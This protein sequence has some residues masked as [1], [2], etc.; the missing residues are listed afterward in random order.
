MSDVRVIR[1]WQTA[2]RETLQVRLR[3]GEFRTPFALGSTA[4]AYFDGET[5]FVASLDRSRPA[6]ANQMPLPVAWTPLPCPSVID[7]GASH[8]AYEA[9]PNGEV[10]QAEGARDADTLTRVWSRGVVANFMLPESQGAPAPSDP[11]ALGRT[12]VIMGSPAPAKPSSPPAML[13]TTI[14][15]G[16]GE[17]NAAPS[18]PG[19]ST[20]TSFVEAVTIIRSPGS[21]VAL[22]STLRGGGSPQPRQSMRSETAARP[23]HLLR[24]LTARA[25]ED[26]RRTPRAVRIVFVALPVLGWAALTLARPSGGDAEPP[27][28]AASLTAAHDRPSPTPAVQSGARAENAVLPSAPPP[29]SQGPTGPTGAVPPASR[30]S[31]GTGTGAAPSDV[32][33]NDPH[34]EHEDPS[35]AG[36]TLQARAADAAARGAYPLAASFYDRL[37]ELHPDRS[38][39]LSAARIMRAKP[40]ELAR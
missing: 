3:V 6:V 39:F 32:Q 27:P 2:S 40:A 25:R 15:L 33:S 37:A 29:A 8:L 11:A 30:G 13:T 26:L 16:R 17:P 34:G 1:S 23:P 19:E 10:R 18:A 35:S 14:R 38:E 4:K 5:L 9:M 31:T 28:E 20:R 21:T 24:R 36:R 22:P 7:L 12:T